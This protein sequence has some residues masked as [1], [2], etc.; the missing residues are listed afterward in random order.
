MERWVP[1]G[2]EKSY[3]VRLKV[4]AKGNGWCECR[5]SMD[6]KGRMGYFLQLANSH[7][8]SLLR[9]NLTVSSLHMNFR[10]VVSHRS[11]FLNVFLLA[12]DDFQVHY[13]TSR[14]TN[15]FSSWFLDVAIFDCW[16]VF[17]HHRDSPVWPMWMAEGHCWHMVAYIT[18]VD[19]QMNKPLVVWVTVLS[20]WLWGQ[21]N[22]WGMLQNLVSG[23]EIL[24]RCVLLLA[25]LEF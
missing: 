12:H 4:Y 13:W 22:N 7:S 16:F 19:V 9:P 18:L 10:S 11:L 5:R 14:E 3:R 20:D 6:I 15:M 17:V 21:G 2:Q 24:L 25:L 8:Q 1:A 23:L